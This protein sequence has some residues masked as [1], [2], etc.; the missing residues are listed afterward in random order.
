MHVPVFVSGFQRRG[1]APCLAEGVKR[2]AW[3]TIEEVT[4]NLRPSVSEENYENWHVTQLLIKC[5][6]AY[7]LNRQDIYIYINIL[8]IEKL[9]KLFT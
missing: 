2:S 1:R 9:V 4:F 7:L 5:L 8:Y 3:D 6:T